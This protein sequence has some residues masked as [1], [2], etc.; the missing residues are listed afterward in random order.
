MYTLIDDL[1]QIVKVLHRAGVL[2][3]VVGGVAVNAHLLNSHRSRTFVTRDI[4]L[5]IRREDLAAIVT[6][7]E[8]S[9]YQ[10]RKMFGGFA[11][12]KP[13][14]ELAE[15]VH[16]LFANEKTRAAQ[17]FPNPDVHPETK[18]LSEFGM[19]VPVVRLPDL[20]RMK[21]T[22]FRPKDETHIEILDECGLISPEL[23]ASLP[24]ILKTRLE[25][26]RSRYSTDEFDPS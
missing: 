5:L 17:V 2:F 24:D 12:L 8:A 22:S 25:E 21:L 14:Q 16:L 23:A 7:A 3:E 18:H 6:A 13:N 26:A 9:G 1:E 10:G 19:S 15:A 4:D 11:L 20:V